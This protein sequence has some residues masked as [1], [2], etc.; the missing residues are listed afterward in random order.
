MIGMD[1]LS[2]V[3]SALSHPTRREILGRISRQPAR[4]TDIAG[5]FDTAMNAVTKHL[6]LLERA[7]LVE[8]TRHGREVVI[9]FRAEPLR[10]VAGWMRGYEH[11]WNE[12]LDRFQENF[13]SPKRTKRKTTRKGKQ[14]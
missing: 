2:D 9:S 8:R 6:K 5:S 10:E 1:L 13:Q 11:F 7:G 12:R 4:F 14:Q 3:M